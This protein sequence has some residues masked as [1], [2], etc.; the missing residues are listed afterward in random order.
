MVRP[1]RPRHARHAAAQAALCAHPLRRASRRP[2]RRVP[3]Q[4]LGGDQDELDGPSFD[5]VDFINRKFPDE[6]ALDALDRSIAAYDDEIKQCVPGAGA[7]ARRGGGGD[8]VRAE[9]RRP[10][11]GP[12][13]FPRRAHC[14]ARQLL[15]S[16]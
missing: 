16:R 4:V 7:R 5:A 10:R 3:P 9:E 11:A 6:R 15:R 12:R 13:V 8:A 1:R 14:R 2:A